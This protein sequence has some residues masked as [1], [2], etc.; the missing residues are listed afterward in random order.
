M[1]IG[2]YQQ[3]LT[4]SKRIAV[5]VRFR[6]EL[7]DKLIIAKWYEGCLVIVSKENW[8]ALLTKLTGRSEIIT[9]P[10]RDTDRFIMGSAY[11]VEPD[12]QGRIILPTNLIDYACLAKEVVFLG[13]GN[14]VELWDESI[15][16]KREEYIAKNA[17]E[18]IE[19]LANE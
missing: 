18:M 4:E 10:V 16:K 6:K 8:Q 11:E 9:S 17:A 7:G 2:Q 12:A 1:L 5:P 14:R 15:W 3:N 19:K 13:L